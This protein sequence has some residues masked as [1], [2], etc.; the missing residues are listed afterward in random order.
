VIARWDGWTLDVPARR[1]IGPEGGVHVEPQ[2]FD[3]LA[4]LIGHRDR[5]VS[6]EELLDEIWG[7]QFVSESALTSRIKSARRAVGDD[8]RAQRYI[9][10]VHGRG[11]QFVGE[12]E[13][14]P[15]PSREERASTPPDLA[16][17]IGLDDEFPFVGRSEEIAE[18][19][20]ALGGTGASMVFIGGEPGIGKT[21]L[22]VEILRSPQT[23]DALV[24]AARCEEYVSAPLQPVR[25]AVGQL[26]ATDPAAFR[27]WADGFERQLV[28]LVPSL[29]RYL[30]EKPTPVDGYA[31]LEILSTVIERADTERPLVIL[32]DD[33]QWSDEPTRAFLA[34]AG[35]RTRDRSL[36][37]LCTYRTTAGDLP[38]EVADWIETETRSTRAGR[39]ELAPL[40]DEAARTL[41]TTVLGAAPEAEALLAQTG[42]HGLFL[43]ESIRDV[44]TGGTSRSSV[45]QMVVARL[46]K[47]DD[48]VQDLVRAGAF[49]GPEF[50][51]SVA[52]AAAG[53]EPSAGLEAADAAVA[54]ELLHETSSAERFRFSHQLV[55]TAIRSSL[56]RAGS[57]VI[58]QRCVDALESTGASG[59]EVA[60]HVIRSV[61]L[62]PLEEAVRRNRATAAE[63]VEQK[64]FDNAIRVY[65]ELLAQELDSRLRAELLIELGRAGNTAGRAERMA[66]RFEEAADL[67]RQNGWT[68]ILVEAA[69]GHYGASPYRSLRSGATLALL[70]EAD[71]ALGDGASPAKARVLAK[72]AV[73]SQFRLPLNARDEMTRR[74][75]EM[76]PD[77]SPL[78]RL[79]LL[80]YRAIVFSNP[81]GVDRLEPIDGELEELRRRFGVYHSDAA[82]AETR[83]LM[84][85]MGDEFRAEARSDTT[86]IRSQPIAEWRDLTLHS[87]L[88][89]FAGDLETAARLCDE[90]G[91]IGDQYWGDSAYYL[92]ALGQVFVAALGGGWDRAIELIELI[93]DHDVTQLL[94][95]H[96]AW[97]QLS[98]GD[99]SRGA[100][101]ASF[102]QP[103]RLGWFREHIMGGNA[104]V[105]AA[106]VAL[107]L[108]D[109]DM[110][111]VAE[112]HLKPYS[113][114]MLGVPWACSLA[115]ADSL[116]RLA[117]R[118]GDEEGAATYT[119]TARRIYTDLGA[120]ALLAR[121]D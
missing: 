108:D 7:D 41:V 111:N 31:A 90:A 112:E 54:A 5:V 9:R 75:M 81:A 1:L 109:D 15:V 63:A 32:I 82:G 114:L 113:H 29:V 55:P 42:G 33:L 12:M 11:Y 110:A 99:P 46:H 27:D 22:A 106:E 76:A 118:R 84:L 35:R 21:R 61:P 117:A 121:L 91:S 98:G 73:F 25:D 44:L 47:L 37:I 10:N 95:M 101:L 39:I 83:L 80:E 52:A 69:L 30:D 89:A 13:P 19:R 64:Q 100:E 51:F 40:D 119:A 88:A 74:A 96:G 57:A 23:D 70:S 105:A 107:L 62:I 77:A 94:T 24:C 16:L 58:H 14:E 104:L 34:R 93:L 86:R 68:D 49:L 8:G 65:E 56:S 72:T 102:I 66:A 103:A 3:V 87:T 116:S 120:P 97:A 38:L 71:A 92:H 59:V 60:H 53:L 85:A 17:A 6:K 50:S 2:V 36:S 78:E 18:A 67:A 28:T 115:A 45:T 20:A 26:A 79:E 43:T 48:T 4:Y